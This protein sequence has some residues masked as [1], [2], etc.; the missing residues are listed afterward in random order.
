MGM[1]VTRVAA[2]SAATATA[3]VPWMSSLKE[4]RVL[5]VAVE[6]REGGA[7]LEVLP[8]HEGIGKR[9]FTAWTNSSTS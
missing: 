7:L 6:E 5:P 2:R 1:R 4:G 3:A 8:L 9:C